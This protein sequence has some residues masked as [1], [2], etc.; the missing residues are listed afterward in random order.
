[1]SIAKRASFIAAILALIMS[2]FLSIASPA[3]THRGPSTIRRDV[4]HDVS[5]PLLDM[6]RNV[7]PAAR[8]RHEAEPVRSIPLPPG[9][10]PLIEDPLR[11]RSTHGF[12][13]QVGLNFDGISNGEHNFWVEYVPP[14]PNG[15]VGSTQYV[16]WVNTY[17]AVFDKG[18]GDLLADPAPG[19]ALWTGFGGSCENNNDGDPVVVYDKLADRW[20][21]SQL[22]VSTTPYML[23]IAV[24]QTADATGH[25]YRYAFQYSYFDD[26]PKMG[27]W[28]DAYYE[29]FN[30]FEGDQFVGADAC[31]Y[32]RNAMLSGQ[33][34]TQV[35]FQQGASVGGLLPADVDGMTAPPAGSPNYMLTYGANTLELYKFHVDFN[36][37]S[38]S[39]FTGPTDIPVAAFT[40]LCNGGRNCVPQPGTSTALDSLADRLMYRLAYRNFGDHES[41]VVNH[42][43]AVNGSSGVRWYEVQQPGGTPVVAQQGT[44]APDSS[45]RWMGSV[46][47]DHVG[48]VAVGYSVSSATIY[49]SIAFAGRVPSDPAGALESETTIIAGSGSQQ[50]TTRWGDYSAMSVDPTDDCTFWYTQMYYSSNGGNWN[51]RL[52][53]FKFRS[54]Q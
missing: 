41:L 22:S 27:V 31:A 36:N 12:S 10:T 15:A 24:S 29:T 32:N 5:P 23:C 38:N 6:I 19:N 39:T 17:F 7:R 2:C 47:M 37:P 18:T 30:M 25:W 1:M 46:A 14:D 8:E 33:A 51:T 54:C 9:F 43:V 34:S 45:Y 44:F 20:V 35:C 48:D 28:P 13:P 4:H 26:Y 21:M 11:R 49:P 40:P 3:Q 52:D 53:S 50:N 16:Q 42:S